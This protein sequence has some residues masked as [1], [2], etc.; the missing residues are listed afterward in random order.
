MG[1]EVNVTVDIFSAEAR[2]AFERAMSVKPTL[3]RPRRQRRR[4]RPIECKEFGQMVSRMIRAY[5]RRVGDAD[6]E[7]LTEMVAMRAQLDVVIKDTV[8]QLR[9]K[10]DFS[11]S[12]IGE[13]VGTTRQAAQQRYG[14]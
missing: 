2:A 9:G 12:R 11:W 8:T 5:G 14:R 1:D 6:V 4:S 13:A 7:D 10:H 3:T